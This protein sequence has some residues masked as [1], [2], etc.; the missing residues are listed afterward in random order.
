MTQ[1][2]QF[3][4]TRAAGLERL[5]AF[6]PRAGAAYAARRNYDLPEQGHPH[7]SVLS[8]YIRHRL[9]TEE[10][11]IRATLVHW[12]P[13]T[14]EKFLQ[15][16]FWRTYWKGWLELRPSVW[17]A[18]KTDLKAAINRVQTESGLRAAWEGACTGQTG[19]ACFDAWAQELVT[20]GYLHNHARMW[21]A[22][23]WI[24]TLQL[25]WTLGADFFLRHL[26]DGDPASN[27]LSWRWV[28]GIQT[29]G[30]TYLARPA[31][32]TKYTEGR[33]EPGP[34][35]AAFAPPLDAPAAPPPGPVPSGD[36]LPNRGRLGLL[37]HEDDLSPDPLLDQG[38]DPVATTALVGAAGRSPL[39]VADPVCTFTTQAVADVMTR[40]GPDLGQVDLPRGADALG[41]VSRVVDWAVVHQLDTVV[42]PWA[43]VGPMAERLDHLA[44]RLSGR[45]IGLARILRPFDQRA[46]PHATKGFF[47]FKEKIPHLL[48]KLDGPQGDLFDHAG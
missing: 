40:L 11:V 13:S 44:S 42:T 35:L 37:L 41:A 21:F 14:A 12:A 25:P 8:P 15:E 34:T 46:W 32:I 38:L 48:G 23:I 45:G 5:T 47:K 28:A 4:P 6:V 18:Y 31:N 7:V 43:P 3:P 30:K 29:R 2:L 9:I 26:L 22:S 17:T 20:T 24:F 33:F 36:A 19:I 10:E 27:T 39:V 1:P 16:V